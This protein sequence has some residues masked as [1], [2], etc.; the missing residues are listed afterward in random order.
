MKRPHWSALP[1]SL[2]EFGLVLAISAITA[3]PAWGQT[4]DV[5]GT[6]LNVL[7]PGQFGGLPFN[8]HTNDQIPL[9]D[10]LTPKFDAVT[11]ADLTLFYK[12][13]SFGLGGASPERVENP[14]GRPG[15]TI[16]RDRYDVPHISGAAR[17]DVM[18][19]A[20]WVA[21]EDRGLLIEV[22][23][24]AGRRSTPSP[25]P[26]STTARSAPRVPFSR[27]WRKSSAR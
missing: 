24:G 1:F 11:P 17:D 8:T 25:S 19:G 6:V 23:R 15:L 4:A 21:A 5:A 3:E 13:E 22:L 9:Y 2:A 16:Q 27:R 12:A 10:G 26:I 7:P 18:F 20:G 14:P